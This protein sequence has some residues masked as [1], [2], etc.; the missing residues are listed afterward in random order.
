MAFEHPL[1][2]VWDRGGVARGA[3]CLTPSALVAE[4]LAATGVNFVCIDL[5]H[6]AI[7][8]SEAVPMLA[9]IHGRGAVPMARVPA[10]EPWLIGKV[11]DA[12]ALG[13]IVPLVDTAQQAA[14][15]VAACRYPPVGRR[16]YGPVRAAGVVGST[17]PRDLD[18]VVVAVMVETAEGLANVEEIAATPGLDAIYIGPADLSIALGL[19]PAFEQDAAVHRDALAAVRRACE[20]HGIVAGV[21]CAGGAMAARRREQGFSM[22]SVVTDLDLLRDGARA[23]LAVLD[24]TSAGPGRSRVSSPLSGDVVLGADATRGGWVGALLGVSGRGE[25]VILQARTIGELVS[26]ATA[27]ADVAVVG[28]DIPIGLPDESRR[29]AD[30][31]ARQF[32]A[33]KASSVFS[34]PIRAAVEAPEYSSARAISVQR[35]GR[36]VSAQ[37]YGLRAKILEVDRYVRGRPPVPVI[38]VHP[39]ASFAE[40]AGAPIIT[41]KKEEGG[42]AARVAA[43]QAAGVGVSADLALRGAGLDDLLDACAAAW[44]A[45]RYA[46]G[47][48]RSIPEEPEHF[49]DGIPAAIIV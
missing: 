3:W 36:S 38:E 21:H 20:R 12:G 14:A 33:G 28:I 24:D 6:G 46:R 32:L 35:T 49:S 26:Q 2:T 23:E 17:D 44:T 45:A 47:K 11:L 29:K 1:N 48:A 5:Q 16:S 19:A 13:V 18:Q 30:D 42:A 34:T 22:M 43:L 9:A 4:T 15:A 37:A 41:A 40:L 8:Y 25:P 7:D 39:E 10:N 31:Q 27:R